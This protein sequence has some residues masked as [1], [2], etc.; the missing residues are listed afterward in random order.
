MKYFYFNIFW[1]LGLEKINIEISI[2]LL[3]QQN[4][5]EIIYIYLLNLIYSPKD[6]VKIYSLKSANG[7]F[8]DFFILTNYKFFYFLSFLNSNDFNKFHSI[9]K[10]EFRKMNR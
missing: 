8:L 3:K 1:S 9:H 6:L 5:L 4:Y 7:T 10:R 2:C